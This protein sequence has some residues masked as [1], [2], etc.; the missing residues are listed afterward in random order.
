[1]GSITLFVFIDNYCEEKL[2]C[3]S[4]WWRVMKNALYYKLN[5]KNCVDE[6]NLVLH[7]NRLSKKLS[8]VQ[9]KCWGLSLYWYAQLTATTISWI[10]ETL[11]L[12]RVI[13]EATLTSFPTHSIYI[14]ETRDVLKC[15]IGVRFKRV[16]SSLLSNETLRNITLRL[17]TFVPP[18][19]LNYSTVIV[20]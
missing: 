13:V 14:D 5:R 18:I 9:T 1:M 4:F 19:Y 3:S 10:C 6:R 16:C 11:L 17:G 2:F 7:Y 20:N 12:M 8:A 15:F